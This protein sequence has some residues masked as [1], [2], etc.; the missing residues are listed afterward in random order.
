MPFIPS[1]GGNG[2]NRNQNCWKCGSSAHLTQFCDD[3]TA[4]TLWCYRC[5]GP[6]HKRNSCKEERCMTCG[7]FGHPESTCT[8]FPMTRAYREKVNDWEAEHKAC[9]EK[10]RIEREFGPQVPK[11]LGPE[12]RV[13]S[14][15]SQAKAGEKRRR[16]TSPIVYGPNGSKAMKQPGINAPA[17]TFGQMFG[18][19]AG[20]RIRP[21]D[22][23]Q[24]DTKKENRMLD[25][26]NSTKVAGNDRSIITNSSDQS[27][28]N[29]A[30]GSEHAGNLQPPPKRRQ[31][32]KRKP[33]NPLIQ[34]PKRRP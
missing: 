16:D 3:P 24:G 25:S 2:L 34:P 27:S 21:T 23:Y 17:D 14:K 28:T 7:N 4:E 10:R 9:Q 29:V 1:G 13:P 33:A 22:T 30:E 15:P 32:K 31:P 6:G 5:K 8:G 26:N 11:V 19:G 18:E 12:D 20:K